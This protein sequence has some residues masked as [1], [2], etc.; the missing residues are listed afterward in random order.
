MT[1]TTRKSNAGNKLEEI[2]VS[3][4]RYAFDFSDEYR[5]GWKQ[6]DTDQDAWYYGV[7]YNPAKMQTLSYTEGDIYLVTCDA[8]SAFVNEMQDLDGFHGSPPAAWITADG[9]TASGLTN[10]KAYTDPNARMTPG[11]QQPDA[12]APITIND[13]AVIFCS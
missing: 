11:M 1:V 4:E 10:P 7:W 3:T 12:L 2:F 5:A 13:V 8:W 9:M 6:Y